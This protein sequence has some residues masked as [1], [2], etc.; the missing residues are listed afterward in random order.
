MAQVALQQGRHAARNIERVSRGNSRLPFRYRDPGNLAVLGR[1]AAIADLGKIRLTGFAAWL[2]WCFV[3][4]LYL[5]GFRNRFLVMFEWAWAYFTYGRGA[6][7]ITGGTR[8]SS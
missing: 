2:F 4:I 8:Q 5:I 3:H 1:A 7:L 6:R